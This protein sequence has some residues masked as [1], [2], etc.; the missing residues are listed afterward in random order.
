MPGICFFALRSDAAGSGA[1]RRGERGYEHRPP[2]DKPPGEAARG[3]H[4]SRRACPVGAE[5]SGQQGAPTHTHVP[6]GFIPPERKVAEVTARPLPLDLCLR[7]DKLV[8]GPGFRGSAV[9][10]PRPLP[11]CRASRQGRLPWRPRTAPTGKLAEDSWRILRKIHDLRFH[12]SSP[13]TLE[14][15]A[16]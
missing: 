14:G 12:K 13:G 3:A 7:P 4:R 5:R 6:G 11:S 15:A 8:G 10:A 2:T 1:F 16:P 9:V